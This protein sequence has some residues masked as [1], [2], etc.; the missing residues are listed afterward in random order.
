MKLQAESDFIKVQQFSAETV[1]AEGKDMYKN[2]PKYSFEKRRNPIES[3]TEKWKIIIGKEDITFNY[4]SIPSTHPS[5]IGAML[6]T[7]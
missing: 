7:D 1:I 2:W 5:T 3:I 4:V 6:V